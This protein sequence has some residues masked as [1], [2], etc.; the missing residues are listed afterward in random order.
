VCSQFVSWCVADIVMFLKGAGAVV[1][2]IISF[3][4][5]K[6]FFHK[7]ALTDKFDPEYDYIIGML[8]FLF[9]FIYFFFFIFFFCH[10]ES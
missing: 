9:I 1:V 4:S 3:L 5:V 8:N 10:S 6:Y 7:P 2:G